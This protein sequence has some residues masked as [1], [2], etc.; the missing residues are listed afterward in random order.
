MFFRHAP[1]AGALLI[2]AGC[3]QVGDNAAAPS[4]L[5][6]WRVTQIDGATISPDI[7]VTM[8]FGPDSRVAGVGACNRYG[9]RY[10]YA[11]GVLT[12][13]EIFMTKMACLDDDRMGVEARFHARLGGD[14]KAAA[15]GEAGLVL[16]DEAGGLVLERMAAD[17]R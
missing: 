16:T 15:Q 6:A 3:A 7:P 17:A 10:E 2:L 1:S 12:L 9:G 5:G 13:R 8:E 4:I 14:L 11:K